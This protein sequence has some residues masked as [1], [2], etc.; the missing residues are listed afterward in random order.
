[1]EVHLSSISNRLNEV[2]RVLT[3]ISTIF[4][5]LT[6]LVG[7]YGMNFDHMPELHWRWAY[8]VLW[9]LM[10]AL[11]VWMFAIFRRRGWIGTGASRETERRRQP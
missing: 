9:A 7:V 3:V 6:F 8:P 1:M 5:P 11:A 2:M 4:I 10:I